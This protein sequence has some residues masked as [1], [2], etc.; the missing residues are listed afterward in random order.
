MGLHLNKFS[1]FICD[2]GSLETVDIYY[3]NIKKRQIIVPFDFRYYFSK[4]IQ[5]NPSY[6][7]KLLNYEKS[8]IKVKRLMTKISYNDVLLF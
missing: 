3:E 2:L 8:E 6:P 1:P 7:E 4:L 5:W